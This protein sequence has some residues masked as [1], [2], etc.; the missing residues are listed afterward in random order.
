M[1]CRTLLAMAFLA[2]SG[3]F[4]SAQDLYRQCESPALWT[5]RTTR[6]RYILVQAAVRVGQDLRSVNTDLSLHGCQ[7]LYPFLPYFL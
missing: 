5:I 1:A 4:A 3:S 6:C 7:G 2:F